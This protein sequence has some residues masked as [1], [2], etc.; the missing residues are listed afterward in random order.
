MV[1]AFKKF[2]GSEE[3]KNNMPGYITKAKMND[4]AFSS[5][6]FLQDTTLFL[7][8]KTRNWS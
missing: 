5:G 6:F 2:Y 8:K 3:E 7:M 1:D 4:Q